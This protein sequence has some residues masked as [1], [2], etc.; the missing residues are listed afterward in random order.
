MANPTTNYGWPM[1]T[2]TDLVTDLPADFAAFGQP[3]DTSL[4]ALNPETTLGDIAYRSAT[5]NTN[6]RLGIG[7]TAQVLTVTGGV[8]AWA[9]PAGGGSLTSLAT[10]TLS[11]GSLN[12]SGLSGSYKGLKVI[13]T[14][15]TFANN[16]FG[17]RLR[18]NND[19]TG[20]YTQS[21]AFAGVSNTTPSNTEIPW[22]LG[23][24]SSNKNVGVCDIWDYANTTHWKFAQFYSISEGSTGGNVNIRAGQQAYNSTSAITAITFYADGD[25][26]T[27]GTYTIYGVN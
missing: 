26:F 7:S 27:G 10:G 19:S 12:V 14:S 13:V 8:P 5:S 20:I 9:T 15:A 17:C 11:T 3:V 18:L 22:M 21:L 16:G 1:P 2:A 24:T 4:K 23:G 25:T 6:T